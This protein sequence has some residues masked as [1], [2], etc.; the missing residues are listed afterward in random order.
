M[1][2]KP[3]FCHDRGQTVP[4]GVYVKL[5]DVPR[6]SLIGYAF[7]IVSRGSHRRP[8]PVQAASGMNGE[9]AAVRELVGEEKKVQGPLRNCQREDK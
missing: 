1:L 7:P 9:R 6:L 4:S 3:S 8:W 5:K 2:H